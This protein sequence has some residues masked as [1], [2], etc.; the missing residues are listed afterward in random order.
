MMTKQQTLPN[1]LSE[2]T[3]RKCCKH[4]I[5]P[6]QES[7]QGVCFWKFHFPWWGSGGSGWGVWAGVFIDWLAITGLPLQSCDVF[8]HCRYTGRSR[9]ALI[10][11]WPPTRLIIWPLRQQEKEIS[12]NHYTGNIKEF[13]VMWCVVGRFENVINWALFLCL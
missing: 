6:L 1:R 5:I 2:S 8:A 10:R 7:W 3:E 12:V 11:E 9:Q 4:V 13:S